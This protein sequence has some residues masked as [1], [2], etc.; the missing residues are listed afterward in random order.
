[1]L[2]N[3]VKYNIEHGGIKSTFSQPPSHAKAGDQDRT[4]QGS[5]PSNALALPGPE[6]SKDPRNG[7]AQTDLI[8]GPTIQQKGLDEGLY[9]KST[10]IVSAS[11]SSERNLST[12]AIMERIPS[13]WPR[14]VWHPPWKC[15]RVISGHL[16]WVRSLAFD[17]SNTWF[18]TGSADR[19]IK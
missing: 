4:Q 3:G 8:V 2:L 15:Y 9:G 1:M 10:T 14:P 11:G 18:C 5:G 7:G 17:P 13:R 16:G 19:T 12:S 6:N